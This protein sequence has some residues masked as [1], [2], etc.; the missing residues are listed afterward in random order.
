MQQAARFNK[1]Y[2]KSLNGRLLF[3]KKKP[4]IL[5]LSP[6][7]KCQIFPQ[8]KNQRL[9]GKFCQKRDNFSLK[10]SVRDL[11]GSPEI[12]SGAVEQ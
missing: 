11:V 8:N 1:D 7:K 6:Q 5:N 4:I 2:N 3:Q 10:F 9:L 12:V